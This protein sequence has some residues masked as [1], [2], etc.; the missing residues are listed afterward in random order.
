MNFKSSLISTLTID[1]ISTKNP[2]QYENDLLKILNQKEVI[3]YYEEE[4]D[5][6]TVKNFNRVLYSIQIFPEDEKLYKTESINFD[7]NIYF[8]KKLSEKEEE[9]I[10][11]KYE[12]LR[13][14]IENNQNEDEV[15]SIFSKTINQELKHPFIY[16]D[17]EL[18]KYNEIRDYNTIIEE[19]NFD[20]I[21]RR[22][23]EYRFKTKTNLIN[24]H[25]LLNFNTM[26]VSVF[27]NIN[28]LNYYKVK[29]QFD[30]FQDTRINYQFFNFDLNFKSS[31]NLRKKKHD[32][33]SDERYFHYKTQHFNEKLEKKY[34]ERTGVKI[35]R[36]GKINPTTYFNSEEFEIYKLFYDN[37]IE[38][39]KLH[40]HIEQLDKRKI[41]V[42]VQYP[43]SKW[44][45]K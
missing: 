3:R 9:L 43:V 5:L 17:E 14:S 15:E 24:A 38:Y 41:Q 7:V 11:E 31:L 37:K 33:I 21:L 19:L 13:D 44:S 40:T 42:N 26:R 34:F 12:T 8:E 16:G 20:T 10:D 32:L 28:K 23:N 1:F 30:F 27:N 29:I 18:V 39:K 36:K 35:D 2:D 25:E 4:F 22:D 6:Q 45:K